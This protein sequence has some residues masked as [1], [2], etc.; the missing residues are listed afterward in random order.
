MT[1]LDQDAFSVDEGAAAVAGGG[2]GGGRLELPLRVRA[3]EDGGAVDRELARLL[4]DFG[5]PLLRARLARFCAELR[6]QEVDG[7]RV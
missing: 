5:V 7:L 4:E 1:D 3:A 6:A 2:G